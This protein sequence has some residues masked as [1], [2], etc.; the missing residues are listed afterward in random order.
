[1]SMER[2]RADGSGNQFPG[3]RKARNISQGVKV[4]GPERKKQNHSRSTS[5]PKSSSHGHPSPK[6]IT[7]RPPFASRWQVALLRPSVLSCR[8]WHGHLGA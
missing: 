8:S 3:G 6:A 1:M 5:P 4:Q 7:P 2:S